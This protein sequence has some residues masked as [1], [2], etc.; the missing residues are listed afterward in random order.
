MITLGV[1]G[2]GDAFIESCVCFL[3]PDCCDTE[4]D[5][6]CVQDVNDFGCGSC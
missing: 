6:F 5:G 2:C 1:P 3:D 4:W